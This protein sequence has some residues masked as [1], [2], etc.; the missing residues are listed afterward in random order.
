MSEDD[1]MY[2]DD[3][4][5][6][7]EY[8]EDDGE[9]EEEVGAENRYYNAKAQRDDFATAL[10]EFQVVVDT[11]GSTDWGFK[12]TKQMLKLCL[13]ES[14]YDKVLSYYEKMLEYV[15]SSAVTR[16][17]AE[18]SINNMLERV[19][20]V[21]TAEFTHRF[22][23]DTLAVLKETKNDRLWLRT[24]L[25]LAKLL[26]DQRE[27]AA[28]DTLLAG[29]KR[30]CEDDS[31]TVILERGTQL[32]EIYAMYLEMYAAREET[33]R[34]KDTYLL[35]MT[36]KSAI[37]HPR[38]MGFIREC[39]GKMYMGERNWEQAKVNFFDAFK[40]Y[41]EAGSPRRVQVLKYLVLASLLSESE[42]NPLSGPEAMSY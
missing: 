19:S 5:Y 25:R 20:A 26:L 38:I 30:E 39:G 13:R 11:A 36:I 34:L 12:A 6:N 10:R 29:L 22:Y 7:F 3:D 27:Y 8:E 33:K 9:T 14:K 42:V 21:A 28:L 32:L 16:N 31:G 24:S 40:N 1:F 18:K 37:P 2:E 35:C 23:Q 41:D 15:R 4:E 17:Y